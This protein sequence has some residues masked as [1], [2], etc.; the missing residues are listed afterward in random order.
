MSR[1][2]TAEEQE[3][4]MLENEMMQADAEAHGYG[5]KF[6]TV[7]IDEIPVHPIPCVR[8]ERGE[9]KKQTV[10]ELVAKI[11]EELIE[12]EAVT[13][14][15]CDIDEIAK[16]QDVGSEFLRRMAEEAADLKTAV[17]TFEEAVSINKYMRNEAQRKVN[18]KNR[19][20]GR[21]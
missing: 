6:V 4:I 10:K 5:E 14:Y 19:E 9:T 13:F 20:R 1:M 2:V 16:E 8:D 15:T 17:T 21:L 7:P 18:E 11:H 3:A 12:L